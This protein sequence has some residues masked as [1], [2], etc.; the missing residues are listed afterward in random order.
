MFPCPGINGDGDLKLQTACSPPFFPS[1][2]SSPKD[3]EM[4]GQFCLKR[5]NEVDTSRLQSG[6][7]KLKQHYQ[8]DQDKEKNR[9]TSRQL[10]QCGCKNVARERQACRVHP[11]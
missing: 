4:G 10:F 6:W 8:V 3:P 2:A 1:Q 9:K 11:E 7:Q 5:S